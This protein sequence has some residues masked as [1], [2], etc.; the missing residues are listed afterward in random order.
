METEGEH[1]SYGGGGERSKKNT[2]RRCVKPASQQ[3]LSPSGRFC[4]TSSTTFFSY[5]SGIWLSL[6]FLIF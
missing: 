3:W 4:G 2:I 1:V 5:I 6:F